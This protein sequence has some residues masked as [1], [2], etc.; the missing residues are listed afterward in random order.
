M[1][2]DKENKRE[3]M[4]AYGTMILLTAILAAVTLSVIFNL[5]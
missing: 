1:K 3:E 5:F 2:L 4:A